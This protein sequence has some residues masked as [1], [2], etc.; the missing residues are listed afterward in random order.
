[1]A[2]WFDPSFLLAVNVPDLNKT[3]PTAK[4]HSR[5]AHYK[6]ETRNI[7]FNKWMFEKTDTEEKKGI[8]A[9]IKKPSTGRVFGIFYSVNFCGKKITLLFSVTPALCHFDGAVD[10]SLLVQYLHFHC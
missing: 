4:M 7:F 10:V 5:T 1:M 3:L 8:C 6:T 9:A 2:V